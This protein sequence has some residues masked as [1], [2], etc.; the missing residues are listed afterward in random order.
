[1]NQKRGSA[2]APP[3]DN[4]KGKRIGPL[5]HDS[6]DFPSLEDNTLASTSVIVQP[7]AGAFEITLVVKPAPTEEERAKMER[8]KAS[9]IREERTRL[10]VELRASVA[11]N[12]TA[13]YDRQTTKHSGEEFGWEVIQHILHGREEDA[14]KRAVGENSTGPSKKP[15]QIKQTRMGYR[16][17]GVAWVRRKSPCCVVETYGCGKKHVAVEKHT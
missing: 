6:I 16:R 10:R 5:P 4:D 15:K 2:K 14:R 7:N 3:N 11:A 1:M 9:I 17:D 13:D 8:F 12:I